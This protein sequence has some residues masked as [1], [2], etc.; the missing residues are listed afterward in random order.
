MKPSVILDGAILEGDAESRD[1]PCA[2]LRCWLPRFSGLEG[3]AK[4][5]LHDPAKPEV[6]SLGYI[7][8]LDI[9]P[10]DKSRL[11]QKYSR[12][13]QIT[14][15]KQTLTALPLDEASYGISLQFSLLDR[16]GF[17][18]LSLV[19]PIHTVFSGRSNPI[20]GKTEEVISLEKAALVTGVKSTLTVEETFGVREDN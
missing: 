19:S 10:L 9:A 1:L 7:V 12:D 17:E 11:P 13:E 3:R 16:D 18:V 4:F 8:K 6:Q 14:V 5:V 15:G 2:C 20:Q